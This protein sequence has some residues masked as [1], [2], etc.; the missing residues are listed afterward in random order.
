MQL[1]LFIE[2]PISSGL[3]P[4]SL[5]PSFARLPVFCPKGGSFQLLDNVV[6]SQSHCNENKCVCLR[7]WLNC[8]R[9]APEINLKD[10]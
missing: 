3:P 4:R 7:V 6:F 9:E 1:I 10:P 2:T 5:I 8:L